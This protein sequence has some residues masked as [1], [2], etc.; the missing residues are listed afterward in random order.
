M[1]NRRL[2]CSPTPLTELPKVKHN[3]NETS[4]DFEISIFP[5]W[6]RAQR[7]SASTLRML[8]K[9]EFQNLE[10]NLSLRDGEEKPWNSR[11]E[12]QKGVKMD[13]KRRISKLWFVVGK[14]TSLVRA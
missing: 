4:S 11:E 1:A 3:N 2:C 13:P 10:A 8:V 12:G 6:S 7:C 14:L 9:F 5:V